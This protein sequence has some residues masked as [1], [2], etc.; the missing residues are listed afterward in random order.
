MKIILNIIENLEI[1]IRLLA[2]ISATIFCVIIVF[3]NIF[4]LGL[5]NDFLVL[6]ETCEIIMGV[7]CISLL[8]RMLLEE[9]NKVELAG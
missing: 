7:M 9:F 8:A 3:T 1:I 6:C 4:M 5:I 2:I